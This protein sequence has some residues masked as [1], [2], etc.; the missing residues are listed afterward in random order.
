MC[1]QMATAAH[2]D[3]TVT[4]LWEAAVARGLTSPDWRSA[5][6]PQQCRLDREGYAALLRD[7]ATGA[8]VTV[9]SGQAA[10]EGPPGS[11]LAAWVGDD[12]GLARLRA[13]QAVVQL[14]Q[15][16]SADCGAA[17]FTVRGDYRAVGWLAEYSQMPQH[18][19]SH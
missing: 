7:R 4:P 10:A 15:A 18:V 8:A 5:V 1:E 13:G 9:H 3:T 17:L 11:V 16:T 19:Q 2:A 6:P 12:Y 14:A